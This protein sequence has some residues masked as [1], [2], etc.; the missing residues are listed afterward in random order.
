MVLRPESTRKVFFDQKSIAKKL[1]VFI[2]LFSHVGRS[3]RSFLQFD[4]DFHL[5]QLGVCFRD[6][7]I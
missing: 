7:K 6:V 2:I 4:N 3:F 1:I 5:E